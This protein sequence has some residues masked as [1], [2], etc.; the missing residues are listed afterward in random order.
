VIRMDARIR[1]PVY[2]FV[3]VVLVVVPAWSVVV[4]PFV[5]VANLPFVRVVVLFA[6]VVAIVIVVHVHPAGIALVVVVAVVVGLPF[7]VVLDFVMKNI[8]SVRV[9]V[10]EKGS[11]Q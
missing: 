5:V 8:V 9:V 7:L 10:D 4:P 3:V 1:G 2:A 11:T 6:R